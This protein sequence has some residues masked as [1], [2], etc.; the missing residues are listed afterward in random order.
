MGPSHLKGGGEDEGEDDDEGIRI[1]KEVQAYQ[2][3]PV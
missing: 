3:P 1:R 2:S